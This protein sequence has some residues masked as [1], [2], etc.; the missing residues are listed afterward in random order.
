MENLKTH[1]R[2]HTGEKPYNCEYPGCSKAFSNASDRAKHQN[3]THSNEKPYACKAPG[4]TK[5]YTDPSSLRKHV[6]TV[7]GPEFYANKK[8]KGNQNNG[9]SGSSKDT[10]PN[11]FSSTVIKTETGISSPKDVSS[12]DNDNSKHSPDGTGSGSSGGELSP[13]GSGNSGSGS[14]GDNPSNGHHDN[15]SP[16]TPPISDNAVSTTCD[17]QEWFCS[18]EGITIEEIDETAMINQNEISDGTTLRTASQ[19]M[20]G[21]R[22]NTIK[23]KIKSGIKSATQWI[24]NI[25]RN[26][27]SSP[28]SR[29]NNCNSNYLQM[30]SQCN[31]KNQNNSKSKAK[32][33]N[34]SKLIRHGSTASS[35]NSNSFY[36][37]VL[38]SDNS[39]NSQMT[40]IYSRQNNKNNVQTANDLV[41]CSSYDPISIG[42]SSRR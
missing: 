33:N 1:L 22:R 8:H 30:V 11:N 21:P 32:N 24:P 5:R 36:S 19:L 7:H 3:R 9:S 31:N 18:P 17:Q 13:D 41:R 10:S 34:K 14:P 28:H 35:I 12:P 37:S 15:E 29:N 25:F 39:N 20:P 38:G 27:L 16:L 6:K 23:N 2:S 26:N 42:G 4:C 40:N